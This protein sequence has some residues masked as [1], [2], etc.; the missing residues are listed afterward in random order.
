VSDEG[1]RD[2][3]SRRSRAANAAARVVKR[4]PK[5]REPAEREEARRTHVDQGRPGRQR[6]RAHLHRLRDRL[7]VLRLGILRGGLR[8]RHP[9]RRGA[10]ECGPRARQFRRQRGRLATLAA[11]RLRSDG[12]TDAFGVTFQNLLRAPRANQRAGTRTVPRV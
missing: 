12:G 5:K 4:K 1:D 3:G 10:G 11:G 7:P 2:E 8:V 9:V 6:H